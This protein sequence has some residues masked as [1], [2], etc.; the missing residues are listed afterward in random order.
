[1]GNLSWKYLA[2]SACRYCK[3]LRRALC[4]PVPEWAS[5]YCG[6]VCFVCFKPLSR[7]WNG[8]FISL[9]YWYERGPCRRRVY[10]SCLFVPSVLTSL[11]GVILICGRL[12]PRVCTTALIDAR[13]AQSNC[14]DG[15]FRNGQLIVLDCTI[16]EKDLPTVTGWGAFQNLSVNSMGIRAH[17]EMFQCLEVDGYYR[18]GWS[19]FPQ[20]SN[21]Q[22][23]DNAMGSCGETTW[24]NP[25]WPADIP[26]TGERFADRYHLGAFTSDMNAQGRDGKILRTPITAWQP[27]PGWTTDVALPLP[28][29]QFYYFAY[30]SSNNMGSSYNRRRGGFDSMGRRRFEG[31]RRRRNDWYESTTTPPTRRVGFHPGTFYTQKAQVAYHSPVGIIRVRFFK[32]NA[33]ADRMDPH[34]QGGLRVMRIGENDNGKIITWQPPLACRLFTDVYFMNRLLYYHRPGQDCRTSQYN[35]DVIRTGNC[36]PAYNGWRWGGECTKDYWANEYMDC[37]YGMN[38][39]FFA[40]HGVF[41]DEGDVYSWIIFLL[42]LSSCCVS[43]KLGVPQAAADTRPPVCHGCFCCCACCFTGAQFFCFIALLQLSILGIHLLG[44]GLLVL[45]LVLGGISVALCRTASAEDFES[46]LSWEELEE[47]HNSVE[48]VPLGK[49]VELS[50]LD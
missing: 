36:Y 15:K 24:K 12:T 19:R 35:W 1:M 45:G 29:S 49:P 17:V 10:K 4:R 20:S 13:D 11:L 33:E 41:G 46:P 23:P 34:Q 27:P 5:T 32:D 39:Y 42:L 21:F 43:C 37:M 7:S 30:Y 40:E 28:P 3:D 18:L 2:Q 9:D 14:N 31:D 22:S 47:D 6:D 26:H 16:P 38:D 50:D 25:P 48:A 8:L 44:L